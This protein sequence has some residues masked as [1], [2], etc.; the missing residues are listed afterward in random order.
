MSRPTLPC[1]GCS[2][3]TEDT[4]DEQDIRDGIH[5]WCEACLIEGKAWSLRSESDL[6]IA[7]ASQLEVEAKLV[8]L[9]RRKDGAA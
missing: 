5:V 8:R 7:K 4:R 1:D 6:L 3:P 2:W 9:E